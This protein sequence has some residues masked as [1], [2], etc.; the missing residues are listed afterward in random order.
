[1]TKIA[2]SAFLT[3]VE[4][5][6]LDMQKRPSVP[7]G[8]RNQGAKR[9]WPPMLSRSNSPCGTGSPAGTTRHR[10]AIN[11]G[12]F[13]DLDSRPR[14]HPSAELSLGARASS[15]ASG[16]RCAGAGDR[17]GTPSPDGLRARGR[18]P[19][20]AWDW[21]GTPLGARAS[22]PASG[23][24][25]AGA[26]DRHG[27]PSPGGSRSRPHRGRDYM[28]SDEPVV[29]RRPTGSWSRPHRGR[30]YMVPAEPVVAGSM[31]LRQLGRRAGGLLH[32]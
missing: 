30:D 28:V 23:E 12:A 31:S 21:Q 7:F 25:C 32:V 24:R 2:F 15:P 26:G 1:M 4:T 16:E 11:D 19:L 8:R 9:G 6:Y 14:R 10:F 5:N 27:P 18:A 3:L 22:S 17:H 13:G 29:S 20:H